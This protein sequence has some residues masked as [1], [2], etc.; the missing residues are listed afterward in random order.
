MGGGEGEGEEL[1]QTGSSVSCVYL[2]EPS[3]RLLLVCGGLQGLLPDCRESHHMRAMRRVGRMG[4][5]CMPPFSG[6][7]YGSLS[8]NCLLLAIAARLPDAIERSDKLHVCRSLDPC[9][10]PLAH[11]LKLMWRLLLLLT[12][13]TPTCL[14]GL[15]GLVWSCSECHLP[16]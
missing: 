13:A 10:D 5:G 4:H 9:S 6:F 15:Q 3:L 14:F 12:L 1:G 2:M 16:G 7:L 8:A 11:E